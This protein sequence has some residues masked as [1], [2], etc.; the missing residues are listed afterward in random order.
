MP[1]GRRS[2]HFHF[3]SRVYDDMGG[4]GLFSGLSDL[5]MK[6]FVL[7]AQS[8]FGGHRNGSGH[9]FAHGPNDVI[10]SLRC[11]QQ[12][13]PSVMTV[14]GFGRTSEVQVDARCTECRRS[15]GVLSHRR[16]LAAEELDKHRRPGAR[17]PVLPE[18]RAIPVKN[19]VGKKLVRDAYEFGDHTV[20]AADLAEQFAQDPIEHAFHRRQLDKWS[21][22]VELASW[23]RHSNSFPVTG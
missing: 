15:K 19:M 2:I 12:S 7:K 20:D 13:G 5:A 11:T 16:R 21:P 8:D 4:A 17:T 6:I 1:V 22:Y 3:G 10:K 14:H 18:L 9:R 23:H